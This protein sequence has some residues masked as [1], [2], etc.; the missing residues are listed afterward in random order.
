MNISFWPK[1][2]S[3]QSRYGRYGSYATDSTC[4]QDLIGVSLSKPHTSRT[5]FAEVCYRMCLLACL[6]PY[7]VNFKC[8]F[9]YFLKIELP[10][11]L[12]EGQMLGY[13][14]SAALTTVAETT[15]V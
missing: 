14:P 7:T 11:A 2:C 10:H 13:C 15:Q 1:K 6:R 5:A 4:K 3:G 12:C 8:V 9:K